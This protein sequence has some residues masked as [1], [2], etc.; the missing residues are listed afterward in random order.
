MINDAFDTMAFLAVGFVVVIIIRNEFRNAKRVGVE[1]G[2]RDEAVGE[3]DAEKAGDACG[4][5]KEEDVPVETGGFAEGEFGA[6]GDEGGDF[7]VVSIAG[8][9]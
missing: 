6:L 3:G 8:F 5:A 1:G 9:G 2:L 4:E 7:L